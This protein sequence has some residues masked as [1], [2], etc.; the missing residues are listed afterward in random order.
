ME[1]LISTNNLVIALFI[2][3]LVYIIKSLLE[4]TK[5][6][7]PSKLWK[8]LWLA[9]TF[10]VGIPIAY[11]FSDNYFAIPVT[12]SI[13]YWLGL[14]SVIKFVEDKLRGNKS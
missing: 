13:I 4:N 14:K 2:N 8:T 9:V 1:T 6:F 5:S 11:I 12:S 10:V 7:V 3:V